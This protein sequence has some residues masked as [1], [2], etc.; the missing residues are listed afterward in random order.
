MSLVVFGLVF[1]ACTQI[2]RCETSNRYVSVP[3]IAV[4]ITPSYTRLSAIFLNNIKEKI[5]PQKISVVLQ[6]ANRTGSYLQAQ[7]FPHIALDNFFPSNVL[8]ALQIEIPDVLDRKVGEQCI[9][10]ANC[11]KTDNRFR[12]STFSNISSFG[13]A[14]VAM[15]S[16][17]QS[18]SFI[19]FIEKLT[20]ISDLTPDLTFADAGIQHTQ[21]GGYRSIHAD[22]NYDK[23]KNAHRRVAVHVYL[24][25]KWKP[26]YGGQLELWSSDLKQ[27]QASILP[28][29][30]RLV[31]MSSTD[32]TYH[33]QQT[34]LNTPVDRAQKSLVINFHTNDRPSTECTKGDC[35]FQRVEV[36]KKTLCKSCTENK[37]YKVSTN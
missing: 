1:F 31:I 12:V 20:G 9:L 15:F 27:C 19:A 36:V 23:V 16:F 17:L 29:L 3:T 7:P 4:N 18:D 22:G 24:N 37:C 6:N 33:G 8:K 25:A 13:P 14:T 21:P 11:Y 28:A 34:P 26:S 30:G 5:T 32:F 35:T 2:A 10:D